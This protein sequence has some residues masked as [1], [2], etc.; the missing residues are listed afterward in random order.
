MSSLEDAERWASGVLKDL[1]AS[2]SGLFVKKQDNRRRIRGEPTCGH[3]AHQHG[4]EFDDGA[5]DVF[6]VGAARQVLAVTLEDQTLVLFLKQN[7]DVLQ[8]QR[9]QL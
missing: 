5:E 4:V 3:R 8:E 2:C 7:E 6:G 1:I 9:V